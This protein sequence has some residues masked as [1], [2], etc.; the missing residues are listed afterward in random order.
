MTICRGLRGATKADS[1]TAEGIYAATR[2]MLQQLVEAN[3]IHERDVAM[4]YLP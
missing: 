4:A 1:N 3:D 2:E